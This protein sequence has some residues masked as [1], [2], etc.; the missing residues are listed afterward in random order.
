[1]KKLIIAMLLGMF[2]F[3]GGE[4][5][6]GFEKNAYAKIALNGLEMKSDDFSL[7]K[8]FIYE[9][10]HHGN[11][12]DK[13]KA[14]C[15][16]VL[17]W[18]TKKLVDKKTHDLGTAKGDNARLF[19]AIVQDIG[20]FFN[21]PKVPLKVK[22]QK[23]AE[24]IQNGKRLIVKFVRITVKSSSTGETITKTEWEIRLPKTNQA[25]GKKKK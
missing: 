15:A 4:K 3:C 6:F 16:E 19:R 5:I 8:G 20:N 9:A 1:M 25:K 22:K 17:V 14:K 12:G 13:M 21:S 18:A 7:M 24:W 11:F 23:A 2:V 10:V